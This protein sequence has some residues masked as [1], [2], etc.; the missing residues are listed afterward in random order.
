MRLHVLQVAGVRH[1]HAAAQKVARNSNHRDWLHA[2]AHGLDT[3][4]VYLHAIWNQHPLNRGPT[5]HPKSRNTPKKTPRLRELFRKVRVNFCL[6]P[7]Y[8]SQG[9]PTGNCSEKLVHMNFFILG[10][11]F[12]VDFPPLTKVR[13]ANTQPFL[14]NEL[15][16]FQ[17]ISSN[18]QA[19]CLGPFQVISD[20]SRQF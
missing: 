19:I 13:C 17:A 9:S 3:K 4:E 1:R 20:N 2:L 16:P 11:F 5:T 14:C 12:R 15:G 7:C 10:G 18:F 8:T 6:R